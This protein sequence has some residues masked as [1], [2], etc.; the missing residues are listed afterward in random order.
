[1]SNHGVRDGLSRRGVLAASVA[2]GAALALP[3]DAAKAIPIIDTHIHL[4]DP[5]RPQGAPY[6][7]PESSPTHKTGSFPSIYAKLARPLGIVGAVEVEA[8]PWVE[9][10]LWV[11]EQAA[12][13][14]IIDGYVRNLNPDAP[15]FGE[16]L[17]RFHKNPLFRGIRYGNIWGYDLVAKA[18]DRAF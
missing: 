2:A 12:G 11:L 4:Y 6:A 8:S 5:N 14:D 15:H 10:N 1:M 3:A 18:N 16:L 13:N 17:G 9:D 7:G